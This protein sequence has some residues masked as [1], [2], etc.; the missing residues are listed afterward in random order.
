M[1]KSYAM[2]FIGLGAGLDGNPLNP[3]EKRVLSKPWTRDDDEDEE[4]LETYTVKVGDVCF[5]AI[6]QIV[7]RP[8]RAVQ[9][10]PSGTIGITSP[11]KDRQLRE[12]VR[13]IWASKD[14]ARKLLD[15]L[16][17]DYAT[18]GKYNGKS[19][20][21]WDDGSDYQTKAAMRLLYYFPEETVPLIAARLRSFDVRDPDNPGEKANEEE[22]DAYLTRWE[23]REV[24]NGV[25]T[26]EF[27]KAVSWCRAP[28]I[29]QAL[30]DL[31]KRTDDP[32]IKAALEHRP[33]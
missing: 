31:A 32:D 24:R 14:P 29:Q 22:R 19:L 13:A 5:V 21:G 11:V 28:A 9:Y 18:E 6:G 30:A 3:L 4:P 16:L 2:C 15:S 12:R 33:K 23:K 20:D 8:Y 1:K 27:I 17:T 7:G 10:V 26:K 25:R